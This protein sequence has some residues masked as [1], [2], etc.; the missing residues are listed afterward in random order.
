[1]LNC[2]NIGTPIAVINGGTLDK[3]KIS[4]AVDEEDVQSILN[5]F[6]MINLNRV[7]GKFEILPNSDI[8]REI[9]YITGCS[10]SGKSYLTSQYLDKYIKKNK[11]NEIYLFSEVDDDEKINKFHP[12]KIKL[13]D[14]LLN[15]NLTYKDFEN[16]LVIFDDIDA[17][18]DKKIKNEV[19]KILGS[20][21]KMGRHTH[22][23]VILTNHAPTDREKTKDIFNESHFI[24]YFP[25]GGSQKCLKYMLQSHADMDKKQLEDNKKLKS[26]WICIKKTFPPH[27]ISEKQ[28]S[29]FE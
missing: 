12:I 16:S 13:D 28:I 4:L 23:S 11:N 19:Y 25:Y 14:E 17:I 10:G 8:E 3:K 9:G 24:V 7:G 29:I 2:E 21:L 1:M 5:P 18:K 20:I 22:T 27:Q 6:K 26:R 15:D